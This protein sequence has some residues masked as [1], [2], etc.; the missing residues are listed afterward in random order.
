MNKANRF[1]RHFAVKVLISCTTIF[2][3]HDAWAARNSFSPGEILSCSKIL[4][5]TVQRGYSIP[6]TDWNSDR[7]YIESTQIAESMG[8]VQ[9]YFDKKF[10]TQIY[11]T[12]TGI[13]DIRGKAPLIDPEAKAVYIFFH[14]SG[15]SKSSGKNFIGNMNTL[16]RMGY[17]AISFDMPF[18]AEGPRALEMANSNH[19]MEWIRSIVLEAKKS[20]KPVYLAGHSYGPDVIFEFITRYPKTA[21]GA[22]ALSPAA[23]NDVL[24]KWY[25]DHTSKMNF[26]GEVAENEEGGRFADISSSQFL[27]AQKKLADPTIVNPNLR[28]R[29]L[30]GDREEYVPAP[31]GGPNGTP[32][33]KNTYDISIPLRSI[34]KNAAITIEPGIGHYLF[35]HTDANGFNV[36]TRELLQV[37]NETPENIKKIEDIV[38]ES[39]K[40]DT[41]NVQLALKYAQ[42]S[43]FRSWADLAFGEGNI[44]RMAK[45]QSDANSRKILADFI[46]AQKDREKIIY[47]K[48][49]DTKNTHPDFYQ[50][51]KHIFDKVD[52]KKTDTSLFVPYLNEILRERL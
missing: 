19:F 42:D 20:G 45:N 29:I 18:H 15:T 25:D 24:K 17:S 8:V 1:S 31:V 3:A 4:S 43:I 27:W 14:G 36:V 35:D 9:T 49:L 47:L 28:V 16:A 13:P 51:Y 22:A 11:F 10:D 7:S 40:A 34:M 37:D 46:N 50:K 6:K 26:G 30:S 38:R 33:G 2:S 52:P 21:D 12:G 5:P 23:F 32:I 48:I 39:K 44:P 41:P